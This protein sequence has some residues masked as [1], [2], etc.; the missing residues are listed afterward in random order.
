MACFCRS[1]PA[2]SVTPLAPAWVSALTSS[3]AA[4]AML[5]RSRL[6]LLT[7]STAASR[8]CSA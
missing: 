3:T 5:S 1:I 7:A 8:D 2:R 4:F 6:P